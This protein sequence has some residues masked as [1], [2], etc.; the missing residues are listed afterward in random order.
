MYRV[1]PKLSLDMMDEPFTSE[2]LI[3]T[4]FEVWC[5]SESRHSGRDL[6]PLP[7]SSPSFPCWETIHSF[8]WWLWLCYSLILRWTAAPEWV[9]SHKRPQSKMISVSLFFIRWC[10]V[11]FCWIIK[12][13][14]VSIS[15]LETLSAMCFYWII[16]INAL[17]NTINE[18]YKCHLK[19]SSKMIIF[20]KL[21]CLLYIY[22]YIYNKPIHYLNNLECGDMAIN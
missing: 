18:I 15:M 2:P 3:S 1:W 16:I 5:I 7:W 13:E 20:I 6:N 8:S 21:L 11:Y 17:H 22:I 14:S 4:D 12:N 10:L 9:Q 19:F